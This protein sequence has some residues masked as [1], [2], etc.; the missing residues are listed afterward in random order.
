MKSN[1]ALSD[2][3][4]S[5]A[6]PWEFSFFSDIPGGRVIRHDSDHKPLLIQPGKSWQLRFPFAIFPALLLGWTIRVYLRRNNGPVAAMQS[7]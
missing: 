1:P 4:N 5:P 7:A 2:R 6:R 3:L